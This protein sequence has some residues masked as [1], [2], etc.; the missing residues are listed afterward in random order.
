ML[1]RLEAMED[2]RTVYVN[3]NHVIAVEDCDG[4]AAVLLP[5]ADS[6]V[7]VKG[8]ADEVARL[9]GYTGSVT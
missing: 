7:R 9:L 2:G 3:T 6:V 4:V 8:T 5:E 1:V